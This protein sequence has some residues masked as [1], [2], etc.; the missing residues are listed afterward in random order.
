MIF[1]INIAPFA[2]ADRGD[3]AFLHNGLAHRH[4]L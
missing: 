1:S 3:V 2:G 4:D